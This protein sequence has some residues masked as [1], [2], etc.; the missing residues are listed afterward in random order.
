MREAFIVA[1]SRT[2]LAKSFRGSFNMLEQQFQERIPLDPRPFTRGPLRV[3][4]SANMPAVL[5]EMG[6]LTNADQ[7]KLLA[8]NEFQ[9]T[10]VQA[11]VDVIVR[12]RDRVA[13]TG[14]A[15]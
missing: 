7:E 6:Y 8:G 10:L 13:A 9:G 15:Q 3:L 14:A 2:P 11:V 12:F 4:E 1:S 5:I